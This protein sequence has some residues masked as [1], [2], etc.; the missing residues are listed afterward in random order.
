MTLFHF[1]YIAAWG[2]A[3]LLA[4]FLLLVFR[5]TILLCN[6]SY[7]RFLVRGWRLATFL[8]AITVFVVLAPYT[9]DPTWDYVDAAFMS[10]LTYA[11]APWA[12]GT[13]FLALGGRQS[14]PYAYIAVCAWLFSASWSYDL[15]L[16]IRDGY[17]PN[18]WFANIFASSVLYLSA[19]LLWN[20]EWLPGRGVIF[21]FMEP[22]WPRVEAEG[23]FSRIL[24][25]AI[26]F[27][28]LAAAVFAPFLL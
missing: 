22:G 3:C 13:L 21:G 27:M 20:L 7:W 18:T 2:S 25:Y 6:R 14:G 11:T 5:R 17:Y 15:Y 1:C 16:L 10:I 19:G 24:L 9:G 8:I 28:I 23:G 26:P 12:V 4:L